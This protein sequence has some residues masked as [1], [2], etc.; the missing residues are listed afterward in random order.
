MARGRERVDRKDAIAGGAPCRDEQPAVGLDADEH[1]LGFL[2]E[3]G[4]EL[5]HPSQPFE[6]VAHPPRGERRARLV[7]HR[8][9]AMGFGPVDPDEHLPGLLAS[10]LR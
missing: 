9:V 5:M 2:D 10:S 4:D 8:N 6:V 1:L 3:R 7:F